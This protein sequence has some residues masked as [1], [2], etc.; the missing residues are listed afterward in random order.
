MKRARGRGRAHRDR[1]AGGCGRRMR[2]EAEDYVDAKLA[3]F[4]IA[5]QKILE[6]LVAT[7]DALTR[8]STRFGLAVRSCGRCHRPPERT[9][10]R[11]RV[12]PRSDEE[13]E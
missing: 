8:R 3:Q 1:G 9:S 4:E 7:N 2:L 5:L 11:R 12:P 13:Q 6:E 10:G